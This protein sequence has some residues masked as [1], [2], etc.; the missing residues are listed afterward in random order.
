MR[1]VRKAMGKRACLS[2]CGLKRISVSP[3]V[4][5]GKVNMWYSMGVKV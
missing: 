3:A 5:M 4:N 1:N 2:V